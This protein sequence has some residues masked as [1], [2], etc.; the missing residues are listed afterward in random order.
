M[1]NRIQTLN[2]IKSREKKFSKDIFLV[3]IAT[4]LF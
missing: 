4:F 3:I 2:F 1:L